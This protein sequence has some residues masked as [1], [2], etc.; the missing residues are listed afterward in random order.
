[1]SRLRPTKFFFERIGD[2]D[3]GAF[4]RAIYPDLRGVTQ[5][6]NRSSWTK[7]HQKLITWRAN[8]VSGFCSFRRQ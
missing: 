1:M 7:Q 8:E 2:V 5:S 3:L 4:S 6:G